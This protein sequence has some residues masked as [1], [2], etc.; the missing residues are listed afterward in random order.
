[1]VEVRRKEKESVG[2][3]LRRFTRRVQ[4]SGI[5]QRARSLRYRANILSK[6]E[7]K[8]EAIKRIAWQKNMEHLRKLGKIE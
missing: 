1:M 3:L 2:V 8:D 7:R 6:R 5:L 4:Q